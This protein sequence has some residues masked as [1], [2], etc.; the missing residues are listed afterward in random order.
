[1]YVILD[2]C[3]WFNAARLA[4]HW[5]K[6]EMRQVSIF[7]KHYIHAVSFENSIFCQR[8][9]NTISV[10]W[11]GNVSTHFRIYNGLNYFISERVWLHERIT[12]R[13]TFLLS[14]LKARHIRKFCGFG[15]HF[16]RMSPMILM[17]SLFVACRE[18]YHVS[19]E[20]Y[21]RL[22]PAAHKEQFPLLAIKSLSRLGSGN[23]VC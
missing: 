18:R 21:W 12:G 7:L 14:I 22:M 20:K 4:K 23:L 3:R 6:V 1:M 16:R 17:S 11:F 5:F 13:W 9:I 15:S 19:L 2:K 10:R 8:C